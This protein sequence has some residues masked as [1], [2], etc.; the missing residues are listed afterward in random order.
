MEEEAAQLVGLT[1]VK[2]NQALKRLLHNRSAVENGKHYILWNG[3]DTDAV[4]QLTCKDCVMQGRWSCY[5]FFSK[6]AQ[7]KHDHAGESMVRV[8]MKEKAE[9]HN[10]RAAGSGLHVVELVCDADRFRCTVCGK[11]QAKTVK[12]HTFLAAGCG[13]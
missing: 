10:L 7:C 6:V 12:Q 2:R 9:K 4:G 1:G 8:K 5:K 13:C 3:D 11:V